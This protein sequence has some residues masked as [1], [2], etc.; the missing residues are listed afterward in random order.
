MIR[1][2]SIVLVVAIALQTVGCS[3]WKPLAQVNPNPGDN[4]Q[5]SVREEVLGKLKEGMVVRIRI[6]EGTSVPI[7]GQV[8]ECVIERV[9]LASL[10]L[11]SFEGYARSNDGTEFTLQYTDIVSIEYRQAGDATVLVGGVV[12]G[13][14]L[15]FFGIAIIAFNEQK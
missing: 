2:I 3:T 12:V 8:I 13:A 4:R 5:T 10:T 7:E 6:H 9:S 15:G 14:I 1:A 11:T